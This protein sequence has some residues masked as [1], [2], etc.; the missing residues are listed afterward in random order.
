MWSKIKSLVS[1]RKG[2]GAPALKLDEAQVCATALLVEVA[3]SDGVY[4]EVEAEQIFEIIRDTF[5][6]DDAQAAAILEEADNRAESA[7]DHH[8]FTK[9]V[10]KLPLDERESLVDN[11]WRV[12]FAD[13]QETPDE[14]AIMRKLAHLLHVD[15]RASRLSRRK[16][17]DGNEN[18]DGGGEV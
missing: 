2:P 8:G 15:P 12:V 11:M 1:A 18:G 3:L 4:A 13:G 16:A 7:A 17:A 6:L 10:K 14:D 5:K 9:V